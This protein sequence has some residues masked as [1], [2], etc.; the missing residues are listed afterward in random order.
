MK[1]TKGSFN[2]M[3]TVGGLAGGVSAKF[4]EGFIAEHT[5]NDSAYL[6][7]IVEAVAGSAISAFSK[8]D[9]LKGIGAGMIGVAG[10]NLAKQMSEDDTTTTE[11]AKTS[12]LGWL[13][14]QNAVGYP[15][16]QNSIQGVESEKEVEKSQNVL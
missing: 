3:S 8:N 12:G 15:F 1:I 14:S 13:A 4:V 6:P 2:I 10:Y 9:I 5:E 7:V 16:Y 11:T